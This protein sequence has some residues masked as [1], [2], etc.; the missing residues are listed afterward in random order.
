MGRN[1][2]RPF[3]RLL[4][5]LGNPPRDY[6]ARTGVPNGGWKIRLQRWV[7]RWN[8]YARRMNKGSSVTAG[9]EVGF[10]NWRDARGRPSNGTVGSAG[11]ASCCRGR[12]DILF[13]VAGDPQM[14]QAE[15]VAKAWRAV[16]ANGAWTRRGASCL[17]ARR[18]L[19][20][21]R[22]APAPLR[23]GTE[24]ASSRRASG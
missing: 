10:G 2:S 7:F 15:A 11:L 24:R 8:W 9:G 3:G 13:L 14:R 4:C 21:S 12:S 22:D 20:R 1:F 6:V 18:R 16:P 23:A 19:R 5:R 17:D